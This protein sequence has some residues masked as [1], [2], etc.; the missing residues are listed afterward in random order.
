M[1]IDF[2]TP[3]WLIIYFHC[4]G[5]LSMFLNLGT[6]YLIL[7]KSDKIDNFRYFLLLFQILCTHTDLYLTFLIIPMPLSPLI[8]GHCNG[9]LASYFKIWSH[10]LIALII[11]ALISQMECLVYCFVRKHQI[12]S[13]LVSRHVLSDGWYVFGTILSFSVPIIV[14]VVFSQAGMRREDQMDYVR[15]NYPNFVQSLLPLD[16]FSIYST[17]PLLISIIIA[18]S[19]GGC[20]CGFLFIIITIEC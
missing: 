15:Q 20:L 1:L 14:G 9:I 17:N 11:T 6:T 13:K 16:N 3:N 18:T 10:Y 8:A 5:S 12:I 7:F 2:T 4:I 19:G